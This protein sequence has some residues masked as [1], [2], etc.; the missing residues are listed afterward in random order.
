M[1]LAVVRGWGACWGVCTLVNIISVRS[2]TRDVPQLC[3]SAPPPSQQI[4]LIL[5]Y[6]ADLKE[7]RKRNLIKIFNEILW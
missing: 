2:Q 1:K 6:L 3:S 4:I 7:A 5:H